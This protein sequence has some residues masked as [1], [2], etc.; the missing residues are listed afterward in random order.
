M[1]LKVLHSINIITYLGVLY[2]IKSV[3]YTNIASI[4]FIMLYLT[5]NI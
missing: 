1:L 3:L 5:K 4:D 2:P